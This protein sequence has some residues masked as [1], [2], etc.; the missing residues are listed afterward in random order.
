M[1]LL[2]IDTD[3]A[4]R[5]P[6]PAVS[7]VAQLATVLQESRLFN[8]AHVRDAVNIIQQETG[9]DQIAVGIKSVLDCIF[10][11]K[12]GG[13]NSNVLETFCDLMIQKIREVRG[14]SD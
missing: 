9:S 3:F 4:K 10:E 12:A 1:K 2:E 14:L 13:P 11:A 6:V 8:S 5:V 7:N